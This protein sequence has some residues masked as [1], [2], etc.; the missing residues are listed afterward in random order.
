MFSNYKTINYTKK[1]EN[2][3]VFKKNGKIIAQT[4]LSTN[5]GLHKKA[6]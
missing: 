1:I 2:I 6:V 5:L 3:W 4:N